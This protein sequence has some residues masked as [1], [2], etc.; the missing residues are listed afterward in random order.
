ME[1]KLETVWAAESADDTGCFALE[2]VAHE[3]A[4]IL[5]V[6]GELD[7]GSVAECRAR[8]QATL[9]VAAHCRIIVDLSQCTYVDSLGLGVFLSL[10][11]AAEQGDGQVV[12]ACPAPQIRRLLELTHLAR[13][14]TIADTQEQ[15][16]ALVAAAAERSGEG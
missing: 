4:L 6:Q 12:F 8:I 7:I 14:M 16:Q 5:A 11:K 9:A 2:I 1:E 15:A 3:P 10:M 13:I